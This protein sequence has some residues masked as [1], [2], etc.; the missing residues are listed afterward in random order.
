M[1]DENMPH[2]ELHLINNQLL[3]NVKNF[4]HD[5]YIDGGQKAYNKI[6]SILCSYFSR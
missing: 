4:Y 6:F 5:K 3:I 1:S 2:L